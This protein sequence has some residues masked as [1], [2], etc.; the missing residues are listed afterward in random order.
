MRVFLVFFYGLSALI[1]L[2][3]CWDSRELD[4]LA[5]VFGVGV[6]QEDNDL[7][8][9]VEVAKP[10][11]MLSGGKSSPS[12]GGK[13]PVL[14]THSSGRTVFD[15]VRNARSQS[16]RQLYFPNNEVVVLGHNLA[17]Q[18]IYPALDFFLRDHE[19]RATTWVLVAED[20]ARDIFGSKYKLENTAGSTLEKITELGTLSKVTGINV[21][22]V[23]ASMMDKSEA[24]LIPMV[25]VT[26]QGE[27][28]R[29]KMDGTAGVFIK[30]KMV[31]TMNSRETRGVKWV[32]GEVKNAS[33]VSTMKNDTETMSSEIS[34]NESSIKV[35]LERGRPKVQVEINTEGNVSDQSGTIDLST[36]Q[37]MQKANEAT[38]LAIKGEVLA[39][40]AKAK[41]LNADVFGFGQVFGQTY[42]KEWQ[43]MESS[44]L[45]DFQDLEVTV[46]VRV[47]LW[48]IG[49]VK[50]TVLQ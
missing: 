23:N 13:E 27:E 4:E 3:G 6:D 2:S 12:G 1:F 39:S 18:G 36:H 43:K 15:A 14:V 16:S 31:G 30:D 8:L 5:I 26:G 24:Y 47:N 29:L 25:G 32:K 41:S 35:V 49:E 44:W 11:Q 19:P 48:R 42:P 21:Q 7:Q 22:E 33:V 40:I 10:A 34:L 20:K 37:D 9:T 46:L 17:K 45:K 28:M 38:A 50:R